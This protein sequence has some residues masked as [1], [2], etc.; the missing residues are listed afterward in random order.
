MKKILLLVIGIC[1]TV[2]STFAQ[3]SLEVRG[4]ETRLVCTYNCNPNGSW[5]IWRN[6]IPWFGYEFTNLNS[7]PVSVDI[8]LYSKEYQGSFR[9]SATKTI[10]LESG[11]SYVFKT[12]PQGIDMYGSDDVTRPWDATHSLYCVKYK[13]YKLL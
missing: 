1:L 12:S 6:G 8:E 10:V 9:L 11:E 5:D 2:I 7:I 3:E 13:A 4:V